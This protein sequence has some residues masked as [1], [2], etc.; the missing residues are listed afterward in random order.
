MKRRGFLKWLGVSGAASLPGVRGLADEDKGVGVV[1]L[2][3]VVIGSMYYIFSENQQKEL[4]S[5]IA[6]QENLEFKFKNVW[7]GESLLIRV[8]YTSDDMGYV[9]LEYKRIVTGSV[10]IDVK[11]EEDRV[12]MDAK[13]PFRTSSG[14]KVRW[15]QHEMEK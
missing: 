3:G 8:R 5:G 9:P 13:I 14:K 10:E 6:E 11:Q 15:L 12:F 1:K 4:A 2:N 7:M